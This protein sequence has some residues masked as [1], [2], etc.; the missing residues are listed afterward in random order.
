MQ[1][2]KTTFC[3]IQSHIVC[4]KLNSLLACWT[5]IIAPL[6]PFNPDSEYT[7]SHYYSWLYNTC[8]LVDDYHYRCSLVGHGEEAYTYKMYSMVFLWCLLIWIFMVCYHSIG[9]LIILFLFYYFLIRWCLQVY[10]T[11]KPMF[12]CNVLWYH[13]EQWTTSMISQLNNSIIGSG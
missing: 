2:N 9:L 13:N 6:V 10:R 8:I 1:N 12:T 4:I 7:L 3:I 11:I 5:D